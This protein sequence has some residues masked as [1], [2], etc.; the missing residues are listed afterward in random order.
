MAQV[1]GTSTVMAIGEESTYGTAAAGNYLRLYHAGE[2]LTG[3]RNL[4][5]S[6][7]ITNTRVRSAPI[8]GNWEV[9]GEIKTEINCQSMLY[10]LKHAIE[11]SPTKT[12]VAAPWTF[13]F[14]PDALATGM[15]IEVDYGADISGAGR[16]KRLLGCKVGGFSMDFPNEGIPS[17][18]WQ[19]IGAK[20]VAAS[21][22]TDASPAVISTHAPFSA[23][24]VNVALDSVAFLQAASVQFTVDNGIEPVYAIGGAGSRVSAPEGFCTISGTMRAIFDS[25][26]VLV[27][28]IAA[29]EKQLKITASV[30]DGLGGSVGN[31]KLV[32]TLEELIFEPNFP[33]VE[34]PAGVFAEMPFK[35][36]ARGG[37]YGIKVQAYIPYDMSTIGA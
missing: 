19:I 22:L 13:T 5:D 23:F 16:V 17:A 28:A 20:P 25:A 11:A 15:T 24:N 29:T 32:I 31:E 26:E 30:G 8:A 4:I 37:N 21:S 1:R 18:T 12:G 27:A 35:C 14:E 3:R 34:G 7:T 2:T 33:R 10:L 36:Y 9:N 6:E